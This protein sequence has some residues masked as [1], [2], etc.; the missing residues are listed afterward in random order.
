MRFILTSSGSIPSRF[1]RWFTRGAY[2]HAALLFSDNTVIEAL[3]GGVRKLIWQDWLEDNQDSRYVI[4][5]VK[6]TDAQ[7][8]LMRRFAED[9]DGKPYDWMGD[10]H[11]LTRQGYA[12]QPNDKWFCSEL[13]FETFEEG[14]VKLF[15]RTE[16]WEVSPEMLNRTTL[17][18]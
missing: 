1:I 12:Q 13:V 17:A 2:S 3:P 11:F 8:E 7:E 10:W 5:S 6:T 18:L 14:G 16:G 4:L 9:Q 15:L